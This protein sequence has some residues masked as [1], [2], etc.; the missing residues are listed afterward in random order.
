MIETLSDNLEQIRAEHEQRRLQIEWLAFN[1]VIFC[2]CAEA[3]RFYLQARL[4]PMTKAMIHVIGP[5]FRLI[6][7]A[8]CYEY[9]QVYRNEELLGV[10][11]LDND[12]EEDLVI[13]KWDE[14]I[15]KEFGF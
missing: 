3:M 13:F 2:R 15:A 11:A 5:A 10:F 1:K 14:A 12:G 8:D 7:K 6:A 4:E 9:I